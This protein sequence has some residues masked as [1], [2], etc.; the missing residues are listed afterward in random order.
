MS[1]TRH[2][3]LLLSLGLIL[4]LSGRIFAIWE[5]FVVGAAA[6]V[7]VVLAVVFTGLARLRL[8]VTRTITPL[9]LHAGGTARVDVVVRNRGG[10]TPVLRLSD[11]VE[12]TSGADMSVGPLH[13]GES[14]SVAYQL[15]TERRGVMNV[16]PL[17]VGIGDPF[18]FSSL[19][20]G[21]AGVH[22][23]TVY[24]RIH[25]IDAAPFTIG[26]DS[27]NAA[28]TP[29]ALGR[30]GDDFYALRQYTFGDDLRRVHWKSTARHDELMVRQDDQPWQGRLTVLLDTRR[31]HDDTTSF[32]LAIEAAASVLQA[33]NRR[34][35]LIRLVTTNRGD[36][37]FASGGNHL[38]SIM[39]YLVTTNPRS[40][41]TLLD[42]RDAILT[43][44]GGGALVACLVEPS[45][46][47]IDE[48]VRMRNTFDRVT[49]IACSLD[50]ERSNS[51]TSMGRGIVAIRASDARSLVSGWSAV[52]GRVTSLDKTT[53]GAASSADPNEQIRVDR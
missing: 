35:D 8:E 23:V 36:S 41:G 19:E 17:T 18:G 21:A 37:G 46:S 43:Q 27:H 3:W 38:D 33:S 13:K 25:P 40:D 22:E 31:R 4:I 2:G 32:E 30:T 10:Q 26:D 11:P 12:G 20:I 29:N 5:L 53:V 34:R 44:G 1:V 15:P 42:A 9:R 51:V 45:D 6:V 49:I 28:P 7:L 39:H 52:H 50:A 48:M 16:G 24:P 47:E 14:L